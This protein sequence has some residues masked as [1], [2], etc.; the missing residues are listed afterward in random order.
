MNRKDCTVKTCIRVGLY[1]CN[2]Y[3]TKQLMDAVRDA[4]VCE[5]RITACFDL[6]PGRVD[7]AS[8]IYGGS[9]CYDLPAFLQAEFDV[10]IICLPPHLHA[11]AF[12]ACAA[13]GKDVYLEKPVCV[14]EKGKETLIRAMKEYH[15]RCYVGISSPY[16]MPHRK[17]LELRRRADA[18]ALIALHHHRFHPSSG[19][20]PEQ[21][22]WRHREEQSGGELNQHCSHDMHYIR[23]VCGEP[24]SVMAMSYTSPD[25]QPAF[26]EEDVTACF[27]FPRG[28]ATFSLSQ[29]SHRAHL[30]GQIHLRDMAITYDWAPH[31][32]VCVYRNRARAPE[33][34]FE[35]DVDGVVP[36]NENK[37]V[38]QMRDFLDAYCNDRPMPITLSDGIQAYEMTKAIRTSYRTRLEVPIP[39][40]M[41][42]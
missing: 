3:R 16:F 34:V 37:D 36:P 6:D 13:A 17:A 22:N 41:V 27:R 26:E 2:L 30:S 38:L 32:R 25:Y 20:M 35:W 10:A 11:D 5:V 18:G 21:L 15:P 19:I 7:Q 23:L 39:A 14:N 4:N 24:E 9:K 1:G 40:P 29:R 12:A 33:E 8:S 31:S 28:M 42:F